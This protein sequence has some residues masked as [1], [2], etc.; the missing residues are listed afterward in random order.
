M[1]WEQNKILRGTVFT[2]F[3]TSVC[4]IVFSLKDIWF[5]LIYSGIIK[6]YLRDLLSIEVTKIDEKNYRILIIFTYYWKDCLNMIWVINC[7]LWKANCNT[8]V[9]KKINYGTK[10]KYT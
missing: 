1:L 10:K 4:S 7:S 5:W 2:S 8:Q 6:N 9:N 3:F